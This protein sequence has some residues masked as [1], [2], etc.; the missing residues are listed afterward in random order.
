M[1][2]MIQS[3]KRVKLGVADASSHLTDKSVCFAFCNIFRCVVQLVFFGWLMPV[4]GVD[5]TLFNTFSF[6]LRLVPVMGVD[7]TLLNAFSFQR[8]DGSIRGDVRKQA[9]DHFN[10][11]GSQVCKSCPALHAN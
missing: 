7:V 2:I 1:C 6:Q 3:N 5:V 8:L 4:W 11:E 9:M 10:A